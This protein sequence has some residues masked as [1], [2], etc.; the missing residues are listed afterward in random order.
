MA[1]AT[2]RILGVAKTRKPHYTFF[3]CNCGNFAIGDTR[4]LHDADR[5]GHMHCGCRNE[6]LPAR[7]RN[8]GRGIL[9]AA[10]RRDGEV[11]W[12]WDAVDGIGW[13]ENDAYRAM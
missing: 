12:R 2:K 5:S 9:Q 7:P 10:P 1:K 3:L 11:R 8:V 13:L 4:R 6:K